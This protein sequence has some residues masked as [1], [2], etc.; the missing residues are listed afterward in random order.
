MTDLNF[1]LIGLADKGA[2]VDMLR[3]MVRFKA[4][5]FMDMDVENCCDA[6]LCVDGASHVLQGAQR[7]DSSASQRADG[8]LPGSAKNA[9]ARVSVLEMHHRQRPRSRCSAFGGDARQS[10]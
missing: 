7:E 2:D 8:P 3:Q 4:Q 6:R 10:A 5:L 9:P 1:A